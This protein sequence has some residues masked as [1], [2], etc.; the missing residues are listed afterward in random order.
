MPEPLIDLHRYGAPGWTC[1]V[2]HPG[3]VIG[4][5]LL[6]GFCFIS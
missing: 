3:R 2:Y 5:V 4:A 6:S 1:A